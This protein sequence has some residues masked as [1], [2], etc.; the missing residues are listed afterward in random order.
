MDMRLAHLEGQTFA[1]SCAHRE[2]VEEAAVDAGDRDGAS[3][4][5]RL[6]RLA[7]HV[8]PIRP[9]PG[10]LLY[11]VYLRHRACAVRFEANRVNA[12]VRATPAGHLLEHLDHIL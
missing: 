9:Q 8:G 11:R 2:L 7:Q 6:E 1:K 3:L 5:A 10:V 12:S 4:A